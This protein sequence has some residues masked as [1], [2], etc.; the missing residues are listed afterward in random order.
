MSEAANITSLFQSAKDQGALTPAA[1]Q[2]LAHIDIGADIQNAMGAPA[3]N[4]DTA[5]SV[6]LVNLR[7]DDSGS[8]RFSGNTEVVR[9]GVNMV[10]E[11]LI[12][13]KQS[14]GVLEAITYINGTV[15][16]PFSLLKDVPDLDT[17]NYN[18]DG[19]TPL[20]VST[21][22]SLAQT[23]AKTQEFQNSGVPVRSITCLVTDGQNEDFSKT[24]AKDVASVVKAMLNTENHII[25]CIGIDNGSCDFK[26][27]FDE[28]GIPKDWVL[29][30]DASD[31]AKAKH[32]IRKAFRTVSQSVVR[33]SQ[34][35]GAFSQTAMGG[36]NAP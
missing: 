3:A 17:H 21:L 8:I 20:Y 27:I 14:D 28:M 11:A 19:G 32:N 9:S 35:P 34:S 10:K 18:P 25:A 1:A 36:F 6:I 29:I 16:C 5:A 13:A 30:V 12:E 33:A 23:V 7:V 22:A 24:T 26:A 2:A 15:I 31:P 4:F